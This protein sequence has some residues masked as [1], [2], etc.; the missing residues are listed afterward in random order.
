[1]FY[2]TLHGALWS[3][4]KINKC[5]LII[6][7]FYEIGNF[8]LKESQRR[9]KQNILEKFFL[10]KAGFTIRVGWFFSDMMNI[11]FGHVT[12]PRLSTSRAL[13]TRPWWGTEHV[14]S[15]IRRSFREFSGH[16]LGW[17]EDGLGIRATRGREIFSNI[18]VPF[19]TF[20]FNNFE[21]I[22][23]GLWLLRWL[24][25][26]RV[27]VESVNHSFCM[28]WNILCRLLHVDGTKSDFKIFST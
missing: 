20:H 26:S 13:K 21:R 14:W 17:K 28:F 6:K 11:C 1:M 5:F 19:I 24:S 10:G 16:A 27:L 9:R 3:T 12:V 22:C 15:G 18:F 4:K 7:C 25:H 23:V 2:K 8:K